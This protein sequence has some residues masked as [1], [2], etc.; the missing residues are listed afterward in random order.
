MWFQVAQLLQC[1]AVVSIFISLDAV[2]R[3]VQMSEWSRQVCGGGAK[4]LGMLKKS[5][6]KVSP[7]RLLFSVVCK[8]LVHCSPMRLKTKPMDTVHSWIRTTLCCYCGS[9]DP[10]ASCDF[11]CVNPTV[12]LSFA[13]IFISSC[14][15]IGKSPNVLHCDSR[16]F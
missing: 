11:S 14:F 2:C 3:D 8:V 10:A 9:I 5:K 6:G 7:S 15:V 13:F 12:L 4:R 1:R 16:V